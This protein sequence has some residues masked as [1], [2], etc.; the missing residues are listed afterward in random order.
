MLIRGDTQTHRQQGDVISI[1]LFFQN[2]EVRLKNYGMS[3]CGLDDRGSIFGSGSVFFSSPPAPDR[4]YVPFS[5]SC[6]G[7]CSRTYR[8][9]WT[10]TSTSPHTFMKLSSSAEPTSVLSQ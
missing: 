9:A 1:L 10:S 7:F 6:N 2:K 4:R 3:G 8:T 5:Y